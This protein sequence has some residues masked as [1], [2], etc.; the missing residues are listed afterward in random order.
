MTYG[1]FTLAK[2]VGETVS[3]DNTQQSRDII[4]VG[5]L[6]FESEVFNFLFSNFSFKRLVLS[7]LT[8]VSLLPRS[9]EG[10][11]NNASD[12]RETYLATM[13]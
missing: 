2:F 11:F 4:D 13:N 3:N 1:S 5:I 8:V 6:C 9:G 7:Y 12:T 10:L